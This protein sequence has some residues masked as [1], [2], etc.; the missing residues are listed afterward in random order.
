[1]LGMLTYLFYLLSKPIIP[2]IGDLSARKIVQK[3]TFFLNYAN[4]FAKKP[5]FA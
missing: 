3:Y 4:F 2:L 1:M 5:D